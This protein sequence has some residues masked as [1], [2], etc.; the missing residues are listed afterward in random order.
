M[1]SAAAKLSGPVET[2]R[3][4]YMRRQIDLT[5]QPEIDSHESCQVNPLVKAPPL[6][7]DLMYVV[8]MYI[9]MPERAG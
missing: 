8:I 1:Y 9:A 3:A 4:H 2:E 7:G 5:V 6:N